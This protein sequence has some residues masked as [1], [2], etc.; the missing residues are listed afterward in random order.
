VSTEVEH[1]GHG[2]HQV[3]GK[4]L[5][6]ALKQVQV[7]SL[8]AD[9]QFGLAL[10]LLQDP[11]GFVIVLQTASEALRLQDDALEA[12]DAFCLVL[13]LQRIRVVETETVESLKVQFVRC[14]LYLLKPVFEFL[15][16]DFPQ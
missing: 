9:K 8:D 1:H 11:V 14:V 6:F 2:L 7:E 4:H 15:Y 16:Q 3:D 5:P 13:T 12:V 10:Q